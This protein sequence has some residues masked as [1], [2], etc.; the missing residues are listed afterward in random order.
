MW[1][2]ST[3]CTKKLQATPAK[4]H[5]GFVLTSK[6]CVYLLGRQILL[7]WLCETKETNPNKKLRLRCVSENLADFL[8]AQSLAKTVVCNY[9]TKTKI[10]M[11]I[12]ELKTK[13]ETEIL[14][15]IRKRKQG[16]KFE[17]SGYESK[18]G[19]CT[20]DNIEIVNKFADLG[21]Y[22][23]TEYLFLDFYKGTPKLYLKYF[24]ESENLEFDEWGGY[25]T[26][27][28]IYEIFKLTIL[29]NKPER[30]RY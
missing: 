25:G 5:A 3:Y 18:T 15:F 2:E 28:I 29:S 22:N 1:F 9:Q 10:T 23:Y 16:A 6:F 17:M 24:N 30:R 12:E 21:I 19:K 8:P 20:V 14:D 4:L 7:I 13:T 11:K 27:E 26:S